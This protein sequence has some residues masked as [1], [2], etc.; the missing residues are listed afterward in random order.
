MWNSRSS[1]C[2]T[3]EHLMV[4]QWII[5]C[6]NSGRYDVRTVEQR[7]WNSG[8][9]KVRAEE[10]RWWNSGTSDGGTVEHL[11][12]EQRNRGGET[13][14]HRWWNIRTPDGGTVEHLMVEQWNI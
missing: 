13:V 14:E 5:S 12:V 4:E 1:D 9:Y 11:M 7:W 2:G 6:R 8:R 3:V 10:Q